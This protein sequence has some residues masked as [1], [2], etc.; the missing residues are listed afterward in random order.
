MWILLSIFFILQRNNLQ[1]N[2][3]FSIN[4]YLNKNKY[5]ISTYFNNVWYTFWN[6]KNLSY[7]NNLSFSSVVT[8]KIHFSFLNVNNSRW[9]FIRFMPSFIL[10]C[11]LQVYCYCIFW[12][13][14]IW[15]K[16]YS[17]KTTHINVSSKY[18]N[19]DGE[20]DNDDVDTM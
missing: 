4:I 6:K 16:N 17:S 13:F 3:H 14:R 5:C 8:Y 7:S 10:S 2:N 20:G 1:W 15:K 12:Q 9:C 18:K 11:V 19:R